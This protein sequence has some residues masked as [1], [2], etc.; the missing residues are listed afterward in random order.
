MSERWTLAKMAKVAGM[1]R[2]AFVRRFKQVTGAAPGAYLARLRVSAAR[3]LLVETE[4]SAATIALS[5][6]YQSVHAFNRVFR[7]MTGRPPIVFR[8]ATRAPARIEC[9][10]ALSLAA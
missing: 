9:R 4:E 3:K 6:G 1:S 5:V 10:G 7:R 8:K 2:A